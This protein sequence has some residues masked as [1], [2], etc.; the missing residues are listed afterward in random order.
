MHRKP[1]P[2]YTMKQKKYTDKYGNVY[3]KVTFQAKEALYFSYEIPGTS[4]TATVTSDGLLC[5][6]EEID[7][8]AA[9]SRW[10][11]SPKTAVKNGYFRI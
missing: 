9:V 6:V 11:R 2:I 4:H 10:Y 7:G 5:R 8:M 1:K 3:Y